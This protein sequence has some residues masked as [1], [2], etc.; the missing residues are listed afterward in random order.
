MLTIIRSGAYCWLDRELPDDQLEMLIGAVTWSDEDD[1]TAYHSAYVRDQAKFF[2]GCA[3]DIERVLTG[4][5][6]VCQIVDY[7]PEVKKTR[8][9]GIN[10]DEYP[11]R[12]L[13][14]T[15]CDALYTLGSGVGL[16]S[17]GSGKSYCLTDLASRIGGE[18]LVI[19]Y[20]IGLVNQLRDDIRSYTGLKRNRIGTWAE[21]V[22]S[23]PEKSDI[24][25]AS[26]QTVRKILENPLSKEALWIRNKCQVIIFDE[27]H[28]AVANTGVQLLQFCRNLECLYLFTA[29]Y[30]RDDS[31]KKLLKWIFG[32]PSPEATITYRMNIDAGNLVPMTVYERH[33]P[34]VVQG[35]QGKNYATKEL[36]FAAM[37]RAK[38]N[39]GIAQD[40]YNDIVSDDAVYEASQGRTVVIQV[41]QVD[42]GE[43]LLKMIKNKS[44]ESRWALLVSSGV[45][46][47]NSEQAKHIK[48]QLYERKLNGVISTKFDEGV[49]VK[50]LD[51]VIVATPNKGDIKT[52]QRARCTRSCD[53]VLKNGM[54]Y[55][56]ERGYYY[57]Y[58]FNTDWFRDHTA[59]RRAALL[60]EMREHP[61]NVY[62]KERPDHSGWD[63][64][65]PKA[66]EEYVNEISTS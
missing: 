39:Y 49:D 54:R 13:Q 40:W 56:K 52:I 62:Y 22:K 51:T 34:N 3:P 29:T 65:L 50:T 15:F 6:Y 2:H 58:H 30:T 12:P 21:G 47:T 4:L 27:G 38:R 44:P 23:D 5:G 8:D 43:A 48:S 28:H 36:L 18:T 11:Y 59:I 55:V 10:Y 25:I 45:K 16:A 53:V 63:D 46:K 64:L 24:V 1:P 19:T 26:D 31:R 66:Y 60:R 57:H 20:K 61:S 37:G 35:L 17:A 41:D 33:L 42:H 32:V 14:K 9:W 7:P